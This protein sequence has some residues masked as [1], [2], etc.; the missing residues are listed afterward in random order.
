MTHDEFNSLPKD[1]RD[2]YVQEAKERDGKRAKE[3]EDIDSS[4]L[5]DQNMITRELV[6]S[7][8]IPECIGAMSERPV[9]RRPYKS[10][11]DIE[12]VSG[13][14]FCKSREKADEALG[15]YK[16]RAAKEILAFRNAFSGMLQCLHCQYF[17]RCAVLSGKYNTYVGE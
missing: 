4:R 3:V 14:R 7:N 5:S 2:K 9:L 13:G 15:N 10:L 12:E 16:D 1:E 6:S 8:E 11:S 17:D